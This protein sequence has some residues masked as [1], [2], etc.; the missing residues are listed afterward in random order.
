MA[1]KVGVSAGMEVMA[2]TSTADSSTRDAATVDAPGPRRLATRCQVTQP[3]MSTTRSV[4]A[5]V[6]RHSCPLASSGTVAPLA[7]KAPAGSR[8]RFETVGGYRPQRVGRDERRAPRG[9][10]DEVHPDRTRRR[11]DAVAAG[12]RQRQD[13]GASG[14]AVAALAVAGVEPPHRHH[15]LVGAAGACSVVAAHVDD[16]L[17]RAL[18]V[19]A[20]LAAGR[21]P[22]DGV[23]GPASPRGRCSPPRPVAAVGRTARP[24]RS[25]PRT[26]RWP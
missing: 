20:H 26:P 18:A 7:R 1:S 22:H 2:A 11:R 3:S 9:D 14:S 13:L 24:S 4:D 21:Q 5:S 16:Q 6:Y 17:G 15:G 10:R 8:L 12:D 25:R 19:Q 23:V